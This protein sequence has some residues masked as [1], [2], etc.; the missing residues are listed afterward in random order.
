MTVYF[1]ILVVSYVDVLGLPS[2][3]FWDRDYRVLFNMRLGG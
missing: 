1:L 2:G 3:V